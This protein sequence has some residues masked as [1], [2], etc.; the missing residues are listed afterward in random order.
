MDEKRPTKKELKAMRKLAQLEGKTLEQKQNMVKW[1][2]IGISSVLFLAFFTVIIIVSKQK[3]S[4]I[5]ISTSGWVRGD[6]NAKVTLV[7]FSDLQCPACKAY[8][9]VIE[10]TLKDFKGRVKLLY[11][12]FP[13]S[14][15][16]N[17]T[18]AA[19]SAEAAGA[20]GKFFE[21]HDK[22][23]EK[24]VDWSGMDASTVEATFIS[25]AKELNLDIDKFKKDLNDKTFEE[26]IRSQENEGA[27][28]GVNS[29]PTFYIGRG[30]SYKKIEG[31]SQVY[32]EFKKEIENALR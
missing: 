9:P 30:E 8:Q 12:H 27:A 6:Q 5:K 20:Q 32:S 22:L 17:S 21:M 24:Q 23:F 7:E 19:K 15:H 26:K 10:Q 1:I 29:T 13:L 25:Y 31:A 3:A 4:E 11:K 2:V 28:V 14:L 18:I 16:K